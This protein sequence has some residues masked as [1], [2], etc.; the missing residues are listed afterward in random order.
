MYLTRLDYNAEGNHYT[1]AETQNENRFAMPTKQMLATENAFCVAETMGHIF[2]EY[3]GNVY[4]LP[5]GHYY[6]ATAKLEAAFS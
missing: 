5:D 1:I 3:I 4:L 2:K 6:A